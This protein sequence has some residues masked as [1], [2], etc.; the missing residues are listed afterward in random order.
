VIDGQA[1]GWAYDPSRP[2]ARLTVEIRVDGALVAVGVANQFREDLALAG[3]GDGTYHFKI[4]LPRELQDGQQH[5]LAA[6]ETSTNR[7]LDNSPLPF[8]APVAEPPTEATSAE[9]PTAS[10]EQRI[11]PPPRI[12]HFDAVINGQAEGWAYDPGHPDAR[13]TVEV[14]CDGNIVG[15]GAA[16]HFRDDLA[17]AGF[18]DGTYHFRIPISYEL[19]DGRQHHLAAFETSTGRELDN[20]PLPFACT[21]GKPPYDLIPR[22]QATTVLT[23]GVPDDAAS[24]LRAEFESLSLAQETGRTQAAREGYQALMARIGENALL[25]CK[26]GE[27]LLLDGAYDAALEAYKAAAAANFQMASAHLGMAT[28]LQLLGRLIDA[29]E[30]A[31]VAAALDPENAACKKRLVALEMQAIPHRVEAAL[32]KGD[33]A[34]AIELLKKRLIHQPQDED[35]VSK[36]SSLLAKKLP[37]D[38][39]SELPGLAEARQMRLASRLLDLVVSEADK[40]LAGV[41]AP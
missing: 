2:D 10:V 30:S 18:G 35:A 21:T 13:L 12:G 27:T 39:E 14:R 38:E 4:P 15:R 37:A 23:N 41:A 17:A 33:E 25:Y 29:A 36:I 26:I 19:L 7:E 9:S 3:Y 20:S 24:A 40:K 8:A 32:A 31:R 22:A 5:H 34:L 1:E 16:D 11:E 28:A 6:V